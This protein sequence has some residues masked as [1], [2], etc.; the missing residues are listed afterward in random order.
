M[1]RINYVTSTVDLGTQG[2]HY[3][4]L[5]IIVKHTFA[6]DFSGLGLRS[7]IKS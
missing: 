2:F 7:M 4:A 3:M 1:F 5:K 6:S